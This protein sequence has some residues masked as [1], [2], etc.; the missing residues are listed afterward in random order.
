MQLLVDTLTGYHGGNATGKNYIMTLSNKE[1]SALTIADRIQLLRKTKGIS[2]EGLAE[3]IGVSRQAISKWESGQSSPDLEKIILLSDY[4]ETT[5]DYLLKGVEPEK[6]LHGKIWQDARIYT[7]AGTAINFIGLVSAIIIWKERQTAVSVAVGFMI[8][9]IGCMVYVIGQLA[10][11][12]KAI[13]RKQFMVVNVWILSRMP[14]TCVFNIFDGIIG[15][16]WWSICPLPQL[17][18]N[19][20]M[21]SGLSWLTYIGFCVFVDVAVIGK[22]RKN[23]H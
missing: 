7:A 22:C 8:F 12:N 18:M 2:Q 1:V 6:N 15:R 21:I 20:L 14:I 9:A 19:S 3:Q 13:A 23:G 11:E 4:F 5:T 10:G 17:G 16:H